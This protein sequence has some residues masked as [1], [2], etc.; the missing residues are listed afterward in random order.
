MSTRTPSL[1]HQTDTQPRKRVLRCGW[2]KEV[3]S[4]PGT[5]WTERG[6]PT[7]QGGSTLPR[8]GNISWVFKDKEMFSHKG[9]PFFVRLDNFSSS[10]KT[11]LG[12]HLSS[13]LFLILEF[14]NYV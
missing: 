10:F 1:D 9:F 7:R 11:Q 8:G 3:V 14:R 12:L 4:V 2:R 5:V 6:S 13:P